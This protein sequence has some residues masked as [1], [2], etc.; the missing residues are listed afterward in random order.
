MSKIVSILKSEKFFLTLHPTGQFCKKIKDKPYYF[1]TNNQE[2]LKRNLENAFFLHSG[3]DQ[4][5]NVTNGNVSIKNTLQSFSLII[6]IRESRQE[7]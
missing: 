3:K 4:R 5:R 2:A 7:N 6:K 1:G